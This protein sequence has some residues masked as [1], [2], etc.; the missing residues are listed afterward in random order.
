[1][2]FDNNDRTNP[3]TM[4]EVTATDRARALGVI[5]GVLT[6]DSEMVITNLDAADDDE[7]PAA[8]EALI[9]VL[10]GE[11]ALGLFHQYGDTTHEVARNML[12]EQLALAAKE[13]P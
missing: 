6:G 12:A 13:Q 10:A 4:G 1:M 11:A 2:T 5:C 3:P 8:R 7:N 9:A